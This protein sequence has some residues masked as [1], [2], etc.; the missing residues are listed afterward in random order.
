MPADFEQQVV[1]T[2]EKP[3][4]AAC[5]KPS[6]NQAVQR[7]LRALDYKVHAVSDHKAFLSNFNQNRYKVV[8]LEELFASKKAG[9]NESLLTLQSMPVALRRHATIILLGESFTT[10]DAMQAFRNSVHAV[11]NVSEIAV[12]KHLV[13]R[14]VEDNDLFL[15]NYREVQSFVTRF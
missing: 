10:F 5:S 6:L 11:V 14:A 1:G 2:Q 7:A 4:L 13:A 3:A 8:V 12:L 9:E 15:H